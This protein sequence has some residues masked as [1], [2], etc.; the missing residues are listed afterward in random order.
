MRSSSMFFA[1]GPSRAGWLGQRD[2]SLDQLLISGIE[3]RARGLVRVSAPWNSN[4]HAPVGSVVA[5]YRMKA[6]RRWQRV[7][8]IRP[9]GDRLWGCVPVCSAQKWAL[10]IMCVWL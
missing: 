1:M 9:L 10:A 7:V 4:D 3:D 2:A 8:A 5:S 6:M